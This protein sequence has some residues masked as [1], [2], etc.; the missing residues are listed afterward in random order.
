V[1]CWSG[2][3]HDSWHSKL[4]RTTSRARSAGPSAVSRG[5]GGC[6][7]Q[8]WLWPGPGLGQALARPW[9]GP[10]LGLGLGQARPLARAR[11]WPGPCQALATPGPEHSC[12]P[13][14]A[15]IRENQQKFQQTS[16]ISRSRKIESIATPADTVHSAAPRRRRGSCLW[17]DY[18]SFLFA[19]LK[20]L[21]FAQF[22]I[23]F[24]GFPPPR[25]G[26][27]GVVRGISDARGRASSEALRK[28][29]ARPS[30]SGLSGA[31]PSRDRNPWKPASCENQQCYRC[32][33][34][35]NST[36]ARRNIDNFASRNGARI[37]ILREIGLSSHFGP[38]TCDFAG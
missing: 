12:L 23:H 24:C 3:R 1:V 7:A 8:A 5:G 17:C 34:T 11:S 35:P 29:W 37:Q 21:M 6:Q 22:V 25:G 19:I 31:P 30:L 20:F 27:P 28:G 13:A 38:Q 14:A 26:A 18:L 10:S 36:S 2:L 32:K 9:P 15:E 33:M 16:G 4:P